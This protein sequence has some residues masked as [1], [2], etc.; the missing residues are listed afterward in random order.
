M[1]GNF[2]DVAALPFMG[3]LKLYDNAGPSEQEPKLIAEASGGQVTILDEPSYTGF[4]AKREE[5]DKLDEDAEV[6]LAVGDPVRYALD[7]GELTVSGEIIAEDVAENGAYIYD[8]RWSH[9]A[10][11]K[12][13]RQYHLRNLRDFREDA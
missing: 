6:A 12:G 5:G 1:S 9:G 13:V 8:V 3:S 7:G 2:E 11:S 10:V 4:L